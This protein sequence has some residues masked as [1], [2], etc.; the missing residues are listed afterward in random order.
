MP[1]IC[2]QARPHQH[3]SQWKRKQQGLE[4]GG[5]RKSGNGGSTILRR[6]QRGEPP[7]RPWDLIKG[8]KAAHSSFACDKKTSRRIDSNTKVIVT[9]GWDYG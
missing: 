5:G 8:K 1:K 3:R 9:G 7:L 2:V 6:R 4:A